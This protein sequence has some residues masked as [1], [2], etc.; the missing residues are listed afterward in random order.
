MDI[1]RL[2]E[3]RKK[4]IEIKKSLP[5]IE[6]VFNSIEEIIN[7]YE[8]AAKIFSGEQLLKPKIEKIRRERR[9]GFNWKE[10][11]LNFLKQKGKMSTS[12]IW[13][14]FVENNIVDAGPTDS[15]FR[16]TLDLL[17]KKGIII[18]HNNPSGTKLW[19]IAIES[20]APIEQNTEI[21]TPWTEISSNF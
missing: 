6:D 3:I 14:M 19:E 4:I 2:N 17:R 8:N 15:A 18:Q 1:A 21:K 13:Q 9:S 16:T 5:L 10:N 12:E 11:I 20:V 7:T